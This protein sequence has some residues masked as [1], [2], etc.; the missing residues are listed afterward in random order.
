[1]IDTV[2]SL[3]N[4]RA[5]LHHCRRGKRRSQGY[6]KFLLHMPTN[7]LEIRDQLL[8]HT[9]T[10]CPYRAFLVCDPKKREVLAAPFR[11]RIIHQAIHQVIGPRI[12]AAIPPNSYACRPGMGNRHAALK[13]LSILKDLGPERYCVKLDVSQYFFSIHHQ[14]LLKMLEDVLAAPTLIPLL[15][16][17][18]QSHAAFA[19]KGV[20][21]PIGNVTSQ[22]FA[23]LYLS[24]IDRLAAARSD[25][26]YIRY[27]DDMVI[28]GRDKRAVRDF[29]ATIREHVTSS[30]KLQIPPHKSM[31][32]GA[33][34]VPFLG[35]VIDH[36][37][38]RPLRR[39][40]RRHHRR[41]KA[42]RRKDARESRIAMSE[43]SFTAW[44]HL[45]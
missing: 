17:L 22:S 8:T 35:F 26:S 34:P 20:G 40:E 6:Q 33:D 23:N 31:P 25:V 24:P 11:D 28:I 21:I 1:M 7:L 14:I 18:L 5:A 37:G 30:L 44:S 43:T 12:H 19:H 9:Y 45:C 15:Q 41:M 39:N 42:L 10:W 38:Y 2:A 32:L 3:A 29:A 27:M 13:L 36:Q 4:L 16:S